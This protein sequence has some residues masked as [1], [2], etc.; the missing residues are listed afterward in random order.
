M[1]KTHSTPNRWH[2]RFEKICIKYMSNSHMIFTKSSQWKRDC[3]P[4]STQNQKGFVSSFNGNIYRWE[5]SRRK[6]YVLTETKKK[7]KKRKK[8]K[9]K[10]FRKSPAR[11]SRT[12]AYHFP[13]EAPLESPDLQGKQW[14]LWKKAAK[15]YIPGYFSYFRST[16]ALQIGIVVALNT[17]CNCWVRYSNPPF[18]QH[19]IL[20]RSNACM[21]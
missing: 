18:P 6:V 21:Q 19:L 5:S 3:I 2:R 16:H 17:T 7:R 15:K 1:S 20:Y 9:K 8:E 14:S 12:C 13:Q 11:S 10:S 4:T